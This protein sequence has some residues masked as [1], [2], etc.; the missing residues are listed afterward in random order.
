MIF[1]CGRMREFFGGE[2]LPFGHQKTQKKVLQHVQRI[3]LGTKQVAIFRP[4]ALL[5][6]RQYIEKLSTFLSEL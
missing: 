4:K 2:V 5:T 6:C 1:C 3:F